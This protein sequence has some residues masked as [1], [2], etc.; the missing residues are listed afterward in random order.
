MICYLSPNT[1]FFIN[2]PDK[3]SMCLF[4]AG[5]RHYTGAQLATTGSGTMKILGKV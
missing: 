3:T 2:I 4:P 1:E 5:V